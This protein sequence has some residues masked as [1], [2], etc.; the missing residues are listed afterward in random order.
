MSTAKAAKATK[1][2]RKKRPVTPKR[3]GDRH[4]GGHVVRLPDATWETLVTLKRRTG[5]KYVDLV[6]EAVE[7]LTA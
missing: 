3:G 6:A 1:A 4:K 5:R 2:K 7:K